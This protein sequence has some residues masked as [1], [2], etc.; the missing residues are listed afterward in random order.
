[1][2]VQVV[3][4]VVECSLVL[5]CA[6]TTLRHFVLDGGQHELRFEGRVVARK[7]K[8]KLGTVS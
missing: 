3:Q 1:M 7:K 5:L 4:S 6:S 8:K 2:G